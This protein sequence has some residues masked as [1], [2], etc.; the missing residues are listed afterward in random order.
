MDFNEVLEKRHSIRKFKDKTI[1]DE[2]IKKILLSLRTSPSAGNLQSY[3]VVIITDKTKKEALRLASHDQECISLAPIIIA[4][5]ADTDKSKNKYGERG[6]LYAIQ[7]ATIA[8]SYAQLAITNL[9]LTSVWVG[10]FN[11]DKIKLILKTKLK[12]IALIPLGYPDEK[13]VITNRRD[14][15]EFVSYE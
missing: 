8:A 15:N 10:A 11:E 1:S 7:D 5:L 9:G 6:E 12:P 13:P 4:L 3:E 2:T 14:L